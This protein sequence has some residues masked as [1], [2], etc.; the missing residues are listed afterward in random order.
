MLNG[1]PI[2]RLIHARSPPQVA[3]SGE[4]GVWPLQLHLSQSCRA[5]SPRQGC[6][7]QP[8]AR[9][10]GG[11]PTQL[12]AQTEGLGKRGRSEQG[13]LKGKHLRSQGRRGESRWDRTSVPKV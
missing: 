5:V 13:L 12:L 11:R 3:E 8:C 4:P 10:A 7:G 2:Q 1:L 6:P 9:W